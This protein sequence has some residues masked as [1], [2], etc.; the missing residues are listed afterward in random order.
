MVHLLVQTSSFPSPCL[1]F[2]NSGLNCSHWEATNTQTQT[3]PWGRWLFLFLRR[4]K[5]L[6]HKE[7]MLWRIKP[8]RKQAGADRPGGLLS[9]LPQTLPS[10]GQVRRVRLCCRR[11]MKSQALCPGVGQ[12]MGRWQGDAPGELGQQGQGSG[13]SKHSCSPFAML[14]FPPFH[15][16]CLFSPRCLKFQ[17]FSSFHFFLTHSHSLLSPCTSSPIYSFIPLLKHPLVLVPI[18]QRWMGAPARPV[19]PSAGSGRGLWAC[20]MALTAWCHPSPHGEADSTAPACPH[21]AVQPAVPQGTRLS[22]VNLLHFTILTFCVP[23]FLSSITTARDHPQSSP[24]LPRDFLVLWADSRQEDLPRSSGDF[25]PFSVKPAPPSW[26]A[27]GDADRHRDLS[28]PPVQL[29]CSSW[30]LSLTARKA[31][32]L[33]SSPCAGLAACTDQRKTYDLYVSSHSGL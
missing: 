8:S 30:S 6:K 1:C 13:G 16:V 3:F 9:L 22:P 12:F 32:I 17:C 28:S 5:S 27:A 7:L 10:T 24:L 15:T 29:P 33:G 11:T 31:S 18:E 25:P 2:F 14:L 26:P 19:T 4:P 20:H 21:H 23:L